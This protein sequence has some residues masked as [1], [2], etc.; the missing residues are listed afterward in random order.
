TADAV[1]AVRIAPVAPGLFT[2]NANGAGAPAGFSVRVG[3]DGQQSFDN[4]FERFPGVSSI[5]EAKPFDSANGN[6]YLMLFGTGIRG[7]EA[8][9]VT[10]TIG[11]V[12]VPVQA[13]AAQGSFAG[14]DQVNLGPLPIVLAN[15]RG[16]AELAIRVEGL[17]ANKLTV[18][19]TLPATGE[20]GRRADLIEANSEMGV[21]ELNGKIYVLGGYP[22]SRVTV[23]T[24]QAYDTYSNAWS[25]VAPLPVGVNHNMPA[26]VNGK[27]Y[28]IGGQTDAGTAFVNLVQEYDPAGNVW[29]VRTPMPAARGG[30]AAVVL[31][32]KIYVAGGRPP[33][34]ADFAVYDPV[35]D[36]WTVLPEMPSQRN[37]LIAAALQGKVYVFG[38]RLEGGFTSQAS[39]AVEIY[40]PKTNAWTKGAAMP[41]ARG[42]INGVEANGCMHVFGG[43]FATGVHADHDVYNPVTSTWM[44]LANMPVAVHGVTG[45]VFLDGLIYAAG[46][47]TMQGGSSGSRLHQVYR[48]NQVCR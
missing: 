2:A 1:A 29:R 34:G 30:G 12:V 23:T 33:R 37:H 47:G 13:A 18:A 35:L 41:K 27:L 16:K 20:W 15:R 7:A 38:G 17:E 24:V 42:G 22:S 5:Y 44:S 48:V 28:V 11:G 32:G 6:T 3:I 9:N 19:P 14:L 31:D 26:A 10:A 21:A 4:L 43:E 45:A 36:A 39:G 40:D 8:R 46:G 25:I